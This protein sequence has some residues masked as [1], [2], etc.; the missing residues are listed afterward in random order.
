MRET[1][2]EDETRMPMAHGDADADRII[3]MMMA[4]VM[5]GW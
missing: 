5:A 1:G 4:V 2:G 3:P